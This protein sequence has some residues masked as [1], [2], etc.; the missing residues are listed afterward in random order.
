M[1]FRFPEGTN[2][3]DMPE[4]LAVILYDPRTASANKN[5]SMGVILRNISRAPV[6]VPG[7]AD[8]I[9]RQASLSTFV[10]F[11]TRY[12]LLRPPSQDTH[13]FDMIGRII[14]VYIHFIIDG[15]IPHVFP[16]FCLHCINAVVALRV[17]RVVCGFQVSLLSRV[18]PYSL[19]SSESSSFE[20][21][22]DK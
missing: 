20:P 11:L 17:I 13:A 15:F 9:I 12:F 5:Y 21:F 19:A 8:E 18:T 16:T 4:P 7:K 14:A 1:A 10:S 6:G 3:V 22:I 2:W